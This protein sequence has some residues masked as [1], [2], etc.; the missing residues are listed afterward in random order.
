M[1]KDPRLDAQKPMPPCPQPSACGA[2]LLTDVCPSVI[3]E[4][5][6]KFKCPGIYIDGWDDVTAC[7]VACSRAH[8]Y[9]QGVC[10]QQEMF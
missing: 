8:A 10:G 1:L 9:I 6:H 7:Q 4:S 3:V 5:P 2:H